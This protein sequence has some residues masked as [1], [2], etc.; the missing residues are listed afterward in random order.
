[1][2]LKEY[3]NS[4]LGL[5]DDTK[6]RLFLTLFI[7]FYL[8]VFLNIYLPFNIDNWAPT[9][10][11]VFITLTGF[12]ILAGIGVGF[13]Q[14]V[15]RRI[16]NLETF[17]V[18]EFLIY[19]FI[20]LLAIT[21]VLTFIY[22]D[23]PTLNSFVEKF[24]FNIKIVTLSAIIPYV[25]ALLI[26]AVFKFRTELIKLKN[27]KSTVTL[28]N[29]MLQLPDDNGNIKFSLPID[30]LLY[31]ES[32]DNYVLIFYKHGEEFKK[33]LLR[34]SLK[35]LEVV[36]KDLPVKRCHRSYMVNLNNLTFVKKSGQKMSLVVCNIPNTI[37]VSKTYQKDFKE[38][39]QIEK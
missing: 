37:Q 15:L 18:K 25:I 24:F 31:L 28:T 21:L 10:E 30:D 4:P 23:L 27:V 35:N 1:M 13:S 2:K 6:D 26:L 5:L 3:L 19:I 17:L 20:E 11:T 14:F 16:F 29:E 9:T 39:L 12:G 7:S 32:T 34:N 33:E 38:Y 8:I 22:D 36:L